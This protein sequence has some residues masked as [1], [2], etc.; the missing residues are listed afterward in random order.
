MLYCCV[1]ILWFMLKC[2]SYCWDCL[3]SCLLCSS[4]RLCISYHKLQMSELTRSC[5]LAPA[6]SSSFCNS[7]LAL[8]FLLKSA[9]RWLILFNLETYLCFSLAFM[10]TAEISSLRFA[11]RTLLS[12]SEIHPWLCLTLLS[13]AVSHALTLIAP[14]LITS[15]VLMSPMA[16][17]NYA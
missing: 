3:N 11:N 8:I 13:D 10:P 2:W 7:S 4:A 15:S 14:F 17:M 16:I 12:Y 9:N 1:L 5:S 6:F